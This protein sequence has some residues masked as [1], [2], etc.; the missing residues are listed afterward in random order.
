MTILVD[1]RCLN[2]PYFTGVNTYV[3]RLLHTLYKIKKSNLDIHI[4]ALGIQFVIWQKLI[5]RFDFLTD[6][7]DTQ[8]TMQE[9][10]SGYT[11]TKNIKSVNK[12]KIMEL[13]IL[14]RKT[15][16]TDLFSDLIPY[17]DFVICPQPRV[18]PIHT[19]SNLITVF[20]DIYAILT[21][22]SKF[23]QNII[24]SKVNCQ[25][26]INTSQTIITNSIC[27]AVDI[28]KIFPDSMSKIQT[29]YPALPV[30]QEI[31]SLSYIACQKNTKENYQNFDL[32]NNSYILALSGFEQRK[33]WYNLILAHHYL[34]QNH[35]WST[36]LV[37]AGS[38]VDYEYYTSLKNLIQ[39]HKI[40]NIIWIIQPTEIEKNN[41]L[42]KCMFMA[43]PSFYEGFGFPIL[44]AQKYNKIVLT[45]RVSSM[46]EIG[47]NRCF[48]INPFDYIDIADGFLILTRDLNFRQKLEQNITQNQAEYSW[49]ELQFKLNKI[50]KL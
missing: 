15:T 38:I 7:F 46:P 30:L 9:Y 11:W 13:E 45:S 23:P 26:I 10:L 49:G 6:L 24:Y 27:T 29:I 20:H 43:Y 2:Y 28:A 25:K 32:K 19:N 22:N 1:C 50:L 37:L 41:L 14:I 16:K 17:F 8:L 4:T 5:D 33:N 31:E 39:K 3:I 12:A 34:H 44:E 36:K 35:N 42:Q 40:Q 48:Y 18:L 21:G 47:K